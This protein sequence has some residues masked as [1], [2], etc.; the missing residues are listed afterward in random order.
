[1][2]AKKTDVTSTA[3]VKAP[4]TDVEIFQAYVAACQNSQSATVDTTKPHSN[5]SLAVALGY[6]N[7]DGSA[8]YGSL[9]P[10]ISK[11]RETF[12]KA[13]KL[14]NFPKMKHARGGKS[15]TIDELTSLMDEFNL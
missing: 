4:K 7:D 10:R 15:A 1:M 5:N 2:P 12:S 9:A 14:D 8:K 6:V 11:L 3:T 13:G